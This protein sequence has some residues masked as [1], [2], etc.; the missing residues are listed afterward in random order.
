MQEG[1]QLTGIGSGER[2]QNIEG[3]GGLWGG[4]MKSLHCGVWVKG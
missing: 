2:H 3:V 4:K 1:F